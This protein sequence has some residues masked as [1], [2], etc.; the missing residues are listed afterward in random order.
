[1]NR[2][3][4]DRVP[5]LITEGGKTP[6]VRHVAGKEYLD[7][8]LEKAIEEAGELRN[9]PTVE[10][11]AD[12][13]EVLDAICQELSISPQQ[14]EAERQSKRV[15]RGAFSTHALLEDI[16]DPAG[17]CELCREFASERCPF[18]SPPQSRLICETDSFLVFP[19]LGA[20]VEGYLLICPKLHLPSYAWLDANRIEEYRHVLNK[21]QAAVSSQYG[22]SILFEHGATSCGGRAGACIDHAHMHLVPTTVDLSQLL[23]DKF[24]TTV[25]NRWE[26]LSEW[27]D[28]PYLLYQSQDDRL[29]IS[30]VTEDIPSQFMRR[31]L[32]RNLNIPD[33]WDWGAYLG[34]REMERTISKLRP[35]LE[36]AV[37]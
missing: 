27:R 13:H 29:M 23:E 17:T 22:N 11:L 25:L 3:V 6:F 1:M 4:R 33:L 35:L 34:L 28:R 8:L 36:P 19:T 31:H 9:S 2:L 5:D 21:V 37:A 18:L 14:I 24:L 15:R 7:A 32:A 12:I 30:R 10:E 16:V 26:D 20:F